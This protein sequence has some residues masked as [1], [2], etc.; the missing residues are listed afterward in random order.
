MEAAAARV[1]VPAVVKVG[2]RTGSAAAEMQ[3][4]VEL[5]VAAAAPKV[6]LVAGMAMAQRAVE[7]AGTEV[8]EEG[9]ATA[10]E[11]DV[12]EV[13]PDPTFKSSSAMIESPSEKAEGR[14]S[15]SAGHRASFKFG[16]VSQVP[17]SRVFFFERL[18]TWPRAVAPKYQRGQP[19][20]DVRALMWTAIAVISFGVALCGAVLFGAAY[21]AQRRPQQV[22]PLGTTLRILAANGSTAE[23]RL[24][25]PSAPYVQA[26]RKH[27]EGRRTALRLC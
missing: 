14:Y 19:A 18:V 5:L 8:A 3:V 10:A 11:D 17:S 22:D 1:V 4:V 25:L 7:L 23:R 2:A 6:E 21:Y 13:G 12:A 24:V 26:M 20:G 9:A 27:V 16:D 15:T